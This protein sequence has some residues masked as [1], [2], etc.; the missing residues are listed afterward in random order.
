MLLDSIVAWTRNRFA[1]LVIEHGAMLLSKLE[2][3]RSLLCEF[4][5]RI[6]GAR[7]SFDAFGFVCFAWIH[8]LTCANAVV[9]SRFQS[10]QVEFIRSRPRVELIFFGFESVEVLG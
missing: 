8:S 9:R 6:V 1:D 3:R 7:V 10:F 2:I 5:G 4:G